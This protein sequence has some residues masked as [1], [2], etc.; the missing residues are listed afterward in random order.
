[1]RTNLKLALALVMG[2]FLVG[3]APIKAYAQ[4][5]ENT[6]IPSL[7]L[8]EADVR[9]ALKALFRIVGVNYTIA[10]EVQGTVTVSLKNTTFETALRTILQQVDATW[11]VEG[12]TYMIIKREAA[13]PPDGGN[14]GGNTAPASSTKIYRRIKILSADPFHIA[15]MIGAEGGSQQ[16]I[17]GWPETSVMAGG[18]MMGGMGGGM[19]GGGMGGGMMGGGMGGMMGGMGGGMMGGMGGGMMGGGMGGGMMGGM[20]GGGMGGGFGGGRWINN[21]NG[22][23]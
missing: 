23:G 15:R 13:P 9:E 22:R 1:M 18:G 14:N 2:A 12:G 19:M 3:G 21:G 7:E 16:Y 4:G 20:G 5:P 8:Q 11:R 17:G 6:N 10:P